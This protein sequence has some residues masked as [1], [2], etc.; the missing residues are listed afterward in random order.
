MPAFTH[1]ISSGRLEQ[2]AP[3]P[4]LARIFS[5]YGLGHAFT[6]KCSRNSGNM[7]NAFVNSRIFCRIDFSSYR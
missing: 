1:S 6:A 4:S 3:Q 5:I 7:L 2:S